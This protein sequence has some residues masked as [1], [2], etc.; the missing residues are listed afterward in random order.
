MTAER[1]QKIRQLL[2]ACRDV[3]ATALDL[4]KS[5]MLAELLAEF[6]SASDHAVMNESTRQRV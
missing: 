6:A 3:D 2:E 1:L 4:E 5:G